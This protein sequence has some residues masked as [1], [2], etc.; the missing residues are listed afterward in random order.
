MPEEIPPKNETTNAVLKEKIEGLT[1][2]TDLQFNSVKETLVDIKELV[3]GFATKIELEDVKKEV[4]KDIKDI[5][6]GFMKHNEDDKLSFGG[7]DKKQDEA[8]DFMVKW[9]TIGA[10]LIGGLSFLAPIILKY[11]LKI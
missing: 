5:K 9:G 4:F 8:K 3:R 2:T 7:I 1:K 10:I 6:E 11:W